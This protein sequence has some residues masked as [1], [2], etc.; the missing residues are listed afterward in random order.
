MRHR[1]VEFYYLLKIISRSDVIRNYLL[2][3]FQK[4]ILLKKY[5]KLLLRYATTTGTNIFIFGFLHIVLIWKK[6]LYVQSQRILG[7]QVLQA[8]ILDVTS[9]FF[10]VFDLF[11]LFQGIHICWNVFVTN[12]NGNTKSKKLL[13]VFFLDFW[14]FEFERLLTFTTPS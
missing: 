10:E 13:A 14:W 2:G 6:L 1:E 9:M 3:N 12:S 11:D 4:H 5:R 7:L 8:L